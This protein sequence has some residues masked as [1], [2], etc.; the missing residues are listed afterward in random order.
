MSDNL[1]LV[2][3]KLRGVRPSPPGK[4]VL[5]QLLEIAYLATLRTEE[6]RFI[7]GSLTFADPIT[8]EPDPPIIRRA[9][10]P[11]FVPLLQPTRLT[12]EA[13][14]KLS[15][16]IDKWS[17]SIAVYGSRPSNLFAWG[18]VDQ[19][20]HQNVSLNREGDGGSG[21]L[22]I[23]TIVME[24]TGELSVYHGSL[25]LG[26]LRQDRL[27]TSEHDALSS[28]SVEVKIMPALTAAASKIT[29]AAGSSLKSRVC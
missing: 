7:R 5:R 23:L 22:G 29:V 11:S 1:D 19:L 2:I 4:Q 28:A 21:N 6:G 15:R 9:D 27:I 20:V 26:S 12:V 16:A 25:F 24:G 18:V 10:Y 3:S 17:G 8:P 13:L 14:V